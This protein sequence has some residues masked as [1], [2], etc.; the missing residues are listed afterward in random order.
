MRHLRLSSL[1]IL[2]C[3]TLGISSAYAQAAKVAETVKAQ[4]ESAKT[5]AVT[6]P[7]GAQPAKPA[8]GAQLKQPGPAKPGQDLASRS[9]KPAAPAKET[10]P[11]FNVEDFTFHPESSRNPFEPILLLKAKTSRGLS[12]RTTK[13]KT[14]KTTKTTK[15][16]LDKV[17]YELEELRLVGIIK[18]GTGMIAMMEDMQGKGM[19]FKKGDYL[20]SNLWIQDIG[21]EKVILGYKLKGDSKK[22]E[23]DIHRRQ[24]M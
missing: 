5:P 4:R 7:N 3:L 14:S 20:N 15:E 22:L 17:D 19:L 2:I 8:D 21:D 10:V 24:D 12:V 13:E 16:K 1:I 23:M 6:V 18:S 9:A 11:K